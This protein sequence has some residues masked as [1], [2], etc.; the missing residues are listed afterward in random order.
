MTDLAK[1][2]W[3]D[4]AA[5]AVWSRIVAASP[6]PAW[7][8]RH[9]VIASAKSGRERISVEEFGCG[10]YGCVMPTSDDAV[11][12]K[13]TSDATEA[14]FVAAALGL[15]F[16]EETEGIVR[17][18]AVYALPG[19]HR[20]RKTFVLWRE[21]ATEVGLPTQMRR[22]VRRDL[23]VAPGGVMKYVDRHVEAEGVFSDY[24]IRRVE[25]LQRYLGLFKDFAAAARDSLK[26]S[27]RASDFAAVRGYEDWAWDYVSNR[28]VEVVGA[29]ML[30]HLTG[31][32][33]IAVALRACDVIAELMQNTDGSDLIGSALRYYLGQGIL[34]A[35]VHAN[36]VGKVE[37]T[38]G[39]VITDPGHAVGLEERWRNV[40]VPELP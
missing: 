2:P 9:A 18:F 27:D 33:R 3:V 11:V 20:G 38:S 34:L 22:E 10:H 37:R 29:R 28:D 35:D 7:V 13:I 1:T 32:R 40:V 15:G 8:P 5:N 12:C 23:I 6:K 21:S 31:A 24:E 30:A 36:N 25:N 26:R 39:W 4:R 16:G 14:V 19:E 17:Y